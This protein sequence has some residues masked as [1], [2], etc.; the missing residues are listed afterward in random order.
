L[1][2]FVFGL[3]ILFIKLLCEYEI[4]CFTSQQSA[5]DNNVM[6]QLPIALYGDSR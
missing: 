1:N 3:L 4:W 5:E 2:M 6:F